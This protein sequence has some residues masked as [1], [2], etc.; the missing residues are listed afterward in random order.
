MRKVV[1]YIYRAVA[2][3]SIGYGNKGAMDEYQKQERKSIKIR[4]Y[5]MGGR[6]GTEAS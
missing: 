6:L 1:Y 4:G 5:I 3:S 2:I